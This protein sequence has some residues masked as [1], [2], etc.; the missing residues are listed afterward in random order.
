M[1]RFE[2]TET[3]NEIRVYSYVVE[4]ADEN[5][6]R[7]LFLSGKYDGYIEENVKDC[8][9]SHVDFKKM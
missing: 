8:L 3:C 2:I 6:A 5:A 9:S 4:A 7:E 1:P